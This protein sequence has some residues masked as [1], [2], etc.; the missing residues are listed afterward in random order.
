[1]PARPSSTLPTCALQDS[2]LGGYTRMAQ[3][4]RKIARKG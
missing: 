4:R 1:M 3:L 2:Q